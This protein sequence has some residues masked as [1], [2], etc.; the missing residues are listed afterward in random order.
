MLTTLVN[1]VVAQST[2]LV[3][4]TTQLQF[5]KQMVV[6]QKLPYVSTVA[7][8]S[9]PSRV[10]VAGDRE[11]LFAENLVKVTRK[12][13][14]VR[15]ILLITD[16]AVYILDTQFYNLKRRIPIQSIAKVCLSE[17]SDNF[18]AI[19]VPSEYD[20]LLAS[21]RKSEIVTVLVE[22][23]KKASAPEEPLEVQ[24]ADKYVSGPY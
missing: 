17:Q 3:S 9:D 12:R 5:F 1:D 19:L 10:D 2:A 8:S 15:R 11:V 23:S 16:M 21:T 24:F 22:A 14:L 18:F 13:R 6:F 20:T 4:V 7:L